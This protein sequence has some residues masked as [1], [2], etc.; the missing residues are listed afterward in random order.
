[1]QYNDED[2]FLQTKVKQYGSH[3]VMTNMRGNIKK[4]YWNIDTQFRDD[5]Q[6]YTTNQPTQYTFTLPQSINNVKSICIVNLELP[7]T[8]N[9]ISTA[10][11]NNVISVQYSG[12]TYSLV[13]TDG[14]YTITSLVSEINSKINATILNGKLNFSV[15][16]NYVK[17]NTMASGTYI[18]NFAVGI[19]GTTPVLFDK[20][21]VKSK[22]GWYMGFRQISYTLTDSGSRISV[23]SECFA[24]VNHP[25]YIYLVCDDFVTSNPN[26]FISALPS[27]ILNKN[28]LAKITLNMNSYSYG[29]IFPANTFNGYLQSDQREY[30]GNTNLQRLKIQLVNEYGDSINLNGSD[31]SFCIVIEYEG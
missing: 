27:S 25:R 10:L 15:S 2:L 30:A 18:V 7:L 11:H 6:E 29:S 19:N 26:S 4:K 1:M 17:I 16:G 23:Q 28:I 20:F 9:N 13:I 24:D 22:L 14:Y 21:N 5:Y 12:T 3:M 8:F 31:F